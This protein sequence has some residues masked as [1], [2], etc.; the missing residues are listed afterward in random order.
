MIIVFLQKFKKMLNNV[1]DEGAKNALLN[2]LERIN[3][4]LE[5]RNTRYLT[6]DSLCCFDCE[7]MTRI[8]HIRVGGKCCTLSSKPSLSFHWITFYFCRK[9]L[10]RLRDSLKSCLSLALHL[11]HVQ[12]GCFLSK[13]SGRSR[14]HKSLQTNSSCENIQARR[15][16]TAN[17]HS[18]NTGI[19]SWKF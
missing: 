10:C 7:L 19:M 6:G 1:K 16:R 18:F 17:V 4:H 14:H 11:F 9:I 5:K 15:I 2:Q 3:A 12:P 13:L 8:Q